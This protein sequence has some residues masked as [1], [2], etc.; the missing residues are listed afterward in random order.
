[1]R[2][3]LTRPLHDAER[4]AA[5]LRAAGHDV[6]LAPL[7][8]IEN[9]EAELGGSCAGVLITSANAARAVAAR[10]ES[11]RSLPLLAVGK[12]SAAAA[13][14]AGFG[15]VT[16]AD[17]DARDLVRL[18]MSK[19]GNQPLLYL[20]GENRSADLSAAGR[21]I[22]T[23]VVYRATALPFPPELG[24]AI[25]RRALDAVMHFSRRNAELFVQGAEATGILPLATTMALA[26]FCISEQ[27]AEPLEAAGAQNILTA[28]QP[29]EASML[30]LAG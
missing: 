5:A 22:R 16:S 8:G 19:F 24:T 1:M 12:A 10:V 9:V 4:T 26:H 7:T 6:L 27:V 15:D 21:N 2:I 3:A 20:A 17:G 14:E 13:R 25:K 30:A 28:M 11:L 23:A 29:D 18:A